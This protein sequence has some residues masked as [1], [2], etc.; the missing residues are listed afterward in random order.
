MEAE[1][2]DFE[3]GKGVDLEIVFGAGDDFAGGS[4]TVAAG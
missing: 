4:L 3:G 2:V 1:G